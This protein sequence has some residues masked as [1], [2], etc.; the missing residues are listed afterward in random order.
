LNTAIGGS[1]LGGL[2]SL[3]AASNRPDVFSMAAVMS[4]SLFWD[5][6]RAIKEVPA[7]VPYPKDVKFWIDIGT[8]EGTIVAEAGVGRPTLHCRELVAAFDRAG[9]VRDVNYKYV[10]VEGAAHNEQAWS[11]RADL[12][13][14]YFFGK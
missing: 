7:H 6:A 1:S 14:T 10:E 12:M 8:R 4:P 13:L 9:L 5:D 3:Y 2:I 11:Q